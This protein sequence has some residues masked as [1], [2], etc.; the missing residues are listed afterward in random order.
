MGTYRST[1][2]DEIE[3]IY[4]GGF[5]KAR[6]AL[7]VT[8]FGMQIIEMPPNFDGYPEH[9]HSADGQEEVYVVLRGGGV[10]HID[11]EQVAIDPETLVSVQ[12]GTM[13]KLVPGDQGIR[14]LVLG[15]VAGSAYAVHEFTELGAPD[16]SAAAS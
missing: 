5:R 8:S 15:G 13:R 1:R 3:A 11:G 7:G 14:V 12:P 16:P 6:A 4:G 2:I 10:L 9:D